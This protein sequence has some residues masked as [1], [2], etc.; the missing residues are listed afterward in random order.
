VWNKRAV[1]I[2][3][4]VWIAAGIA[5]LW[6]WTSSCIETFGE[7]GASTT[8]G[9]CGPLAGLALF[10]WISVGASISLLIAYW[11]RNR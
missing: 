5:I 2:A 7:F 9:N 6:P 3:A 4:L 8:I 11:M 1:V 10:V